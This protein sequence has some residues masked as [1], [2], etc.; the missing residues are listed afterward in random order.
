MA[1][2]TLLAMHNVGEAEESMS[3]CESQEAT[4]RIPD[5][6]KKLHIQRIALL[7][8]G[9]VATACP[10]LKDIQQGNRPV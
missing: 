8:K 7:W 10:P 4:L 9:T 2:D 5:T 3:A 1:L 6:L